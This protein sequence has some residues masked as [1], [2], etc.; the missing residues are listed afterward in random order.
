M[1]SVN[2]WDTARHGRKHIYPLREES[3]SRAEGLIMEVLSPKLHDL[4]AEALPDNVDLIVDRLA[5]VELTNAMEFEQTVNDV[6][7]EIG[8]DNVDAIGDRLLELQMISEYELEQSVNAVVSEISR[9]NMA[10]EMNSNI[11]EVTV[12]CPGEVEPAHFADFQQNDCSQQK[13]SMGIDSFSAA[14]RSQIR[15]HLDL[16]ENTWQQEHLPKQESFN[17]DKLSGHTS[18]SL[19]QGATHEEVAQTK[20]AL[21][22]ADVTHRR[23]ER[24]LHSC[25][26]KLEQQLERHRVD[27]KRIAELTLLLAQCRGEAAALDRL[28]H[29]D[30]EALQAQI[31]FAAERLQRHRLHRLQRQVDEN[32]CRVCL[33]RLRKVVLLPCKHMPLCV[34]CLGNLEH[35]MCPICRAQIEDIIETF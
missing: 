13:D 5:E 19:P 6:M 22:A 17:W 31:S 20:Q 15:D 26:S 23:L 34:E 32:T 11:V 27:E 14:V 9:A 3:S 33:E 8:A 12:D 1:P 7:N 25:Q 29:E 30:L 24:E 35:A 4:L 18:T 16:K 28:S 21:E 10:P 2:F